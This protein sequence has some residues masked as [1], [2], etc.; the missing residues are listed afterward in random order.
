MMYTNNI[1][2]LDVSMLNAVLNNTCQV[3]HPLC[4]VLCAAKYYMLNAKCY[5]F[6][7]LRYIQP[8]QP[9][10]PGQVTSSCMPRMSSTAAA[11][12]QLLVFRNPW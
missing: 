1:L 3:L 11:I 9:G 2:L 7:A 5:M 12:R 10:Q 8:K 4:F 6:R